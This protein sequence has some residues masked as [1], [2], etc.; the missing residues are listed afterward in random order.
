MDTQLSEEQQALEASCQKLLEKEWPLERALKALGPGGGG[1][2][3]ALWN[4]LAEAGWLGLPF[5]PELGG[6]GGD[7][8]DLGLAW[9]AAGERL[10]PGTLYSCGFAQLLI[11]RLATPAQKQALMPAIIAGERLATVAYTEPH[12]AEAMRLY[13]TT[14]SRGA[15]GWTLHGV[16][17]FVPDAGTADVVLVLAKAQSNLERGHFGLFALTRAQLGAGIRRQ[18]ALGGE[19]L[20]RV[21]LPGLHVA[22]DALLGGE[23]ALGATHGAFQDVVEQ[24]IALQ[25]M[26]M[27]GG[28]G[29]VLKR[30]VE[31]VREREQ[32]GRA[33][34]SFQAVQ[35][36]LANVALQL[37]GARVAALQALF[38]K[39]RGRPAA[40]A[41]AI[42]KA[43][44]GE[45]YA[46]ATTTAHQL[47]GA[48]GYARETGLYLWSERARVADATFGTSAYHLSR[49][50]GLMGF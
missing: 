44:L 33:L 21:E 19:A 40:R 31:F 34:G 2:S 10:V 1:H 26:E 48:M 30:T 22:A 47:W 6:A 29:A 23:A 3:A 38:L 5:A 28:I 37:D 8:M 25:C 7:L 50:A 24:A 49:L 17:A 35:H 39:A 27:T 11:D 41:A 18:S 9:R 42:A 46:Q 16:K 45:L 15:G 32:H 36:L 43:A 4:T 20:Y 12:A 13:K 14:A